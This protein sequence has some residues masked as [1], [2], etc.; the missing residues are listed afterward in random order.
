LDYGD[1]AGFGRWVMESFATDRPPP[2]RAELLAKLGAYTPEKR[3]E[4]LGGHCEVARMFGTR[5]GLPRA[6]LDG[7]EHVYERWDGLGAPKQV[8]GEAIPITVRVMSLCNE[9]EIHH[10]LGGSS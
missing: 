5:L 6:V 9:L 10:Q 3:R 4:T 8:A 1:P 2:E 7:L